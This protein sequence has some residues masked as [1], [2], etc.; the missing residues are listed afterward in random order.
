[1]A[2]EKLTTAR[3]VQ[4]LVV[5]AV[6]ITAFT[7]RTLD[8][9]PESK[10]LSCVLKDQS[11]SVSIKDDTVVISVIKQEDTLKRVEVVSNVKPQSVTALEGK[12][13]IV[14]ADISS[15]A[16]SANTK[17]IY[18]VNNTDAVLINGKLNLII[19]QDQVEI[20]F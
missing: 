18:G 9:S 17:Y 16:D 3:L 4:I 19:D 5:L 13:K 15:E 1:M 10:E 6:L 14:L 2:A 7:W 8:Y 20:N 12:N 11:C